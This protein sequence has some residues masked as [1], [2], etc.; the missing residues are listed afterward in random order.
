MYWKGFPAQ[1][2][3]LVSYSEKHL[4][5]SAPSQGCQHDQHDEHDNQQI[6]AT[7][8]RKPEMGFNVAQSEVSVL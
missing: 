1:A 2:G 4:P 3:T 7:I 5:K 8:K 6:I